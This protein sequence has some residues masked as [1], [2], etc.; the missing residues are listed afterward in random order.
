[1]ALYEATRQHDQEAL[2]VIASVFMD[3]KQPA[4]LRSSR[5]PMN[6]SAT[7]SEPFGPIAKDLKL[8]RHPKIPRL[9]FSEPRVFETKADAL[10]TSS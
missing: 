2:R 1:M 3:E 8:P 4:A 6:A 7:R 9:N 5:R 10:E